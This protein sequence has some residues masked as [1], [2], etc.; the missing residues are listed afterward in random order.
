MSTNTA[1]AT[2][3]TSG[4][5]MGLASGDAVGSTTI[6]A[7]NAGMTGMASLEVTS[8]VLVSIDLEPDPLSV[9]EGKTGLLTALGTYTDTATDADR[10]DIT[11]DMDG[12]T[13]VDT[14]IAT[15]VDGTVTGVKFGS[16]TV[17]ATKGGVTSAPATINV[18]PK[19]VSIPIS[20]EDI[21]LSGGD[22]EFLTALAEYSD[23]TTNVDVTSSVVWNV[24][25]PSVV[26]ITSTNSG[27]VE[28]G[29]ISYGTTQITASLDSVTSNEIT[30]TAC[31]DLIGACVDKVDVGSGK[32]FTSGPSVAFSD[33]IG[34]PYSTGSEG[35]ARYNFDQMPVLC[36]T[37]NSIALFERTNWRAA[38]TSELLD[39]LYLN[40]VNLEG[41]RGWSMALRYYSGAETPLES[42]DLEA[43]V[44]YSV[45]NPLNSYLVSCV[46]EP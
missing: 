24:E 6:Q 32:L 39:E 14:G 4:A 17:T 1:A 5:D 16:T 7:T 42:V 25:D 21:Y 26:N 13:P 27:I 22:R 9:E 36:E 40:H 19:L 46:S 43:G 38:I 30:I 28:G 34:V 37:Y 2:I 41:E 20:P 31:N 45:P 3:S 35:F 10:V 29:S 12:W 15:V 44:A 8:A 23:G 11:S 18:T 33:A